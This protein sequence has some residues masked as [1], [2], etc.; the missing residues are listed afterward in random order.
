MF[1]REFLLSVLAGVAQARGA[2]SLPPVRRLTHGPRFH[3]FGYYDKWQFDP[4]GRYAL[5]MQV[6]FEHRTP[7]PDD[8][9]KIGMIDLHDGDRWIELGDSRAWNWQQGCMLQFVPGSKT[10]I[11]WNDRVKEGNEERFVAHILNIQT[12][13]RRM[14]PA[15]IYALSPDGRTAVAPDF[16]RLND[17]RPGYGYAAIADPFRNE[18]AP[19][20]A[21]IWKMDLRTGKQQLIVSLADIAALPYQEKSRPVHNDPASS[22]HW[23][24]HLLFAPDGKRFLWLHRWREMTGDEARQSLSGGGAKPFSTRMFT[25]D[26]NGGARYIVDPYGGTSHFIWR[27]AQHI[28]AW[29][30]HPSRNQQ[31]FYLYRDQTTEVE[32]IAPDVMTENGHNTYLPRRNNEWILND[33]YPDKERL[34]HPYLYHIPTNRRIPLGHFHSPPAYV[35]EWRCDTHPRYSPDGTK[36]VIDSTHEGLGRQMY[37]IDIGKLIN[38]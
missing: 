6:S 24:N 12:R 9:I 30:W 2:A 32:S 5:G 26:V 13:K 37:L 4:T 1:R 7:G 18:R 8:I 11:I 27:D 15:P 21:G 17:C 10:D 34:Q 31:R 25:A 35:G 38:T 14:L 36:V 16:R 22:K 3:W 33:T 23:F 29:A 28:A 20:D 19:R